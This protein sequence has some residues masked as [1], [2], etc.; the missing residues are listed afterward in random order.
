MEKP[1]Y[2]GGY[3][4]AGL[5][6]NP[7]ILNQVGAINLNVQQNTMT[8]QKYTDTI[9][10]KIQT[11]E[12]NKRRSL[13]SVFIATQNN[14]AIFLVS[15]YDNGDIEGELLT[16]SVVGNW[17][18]YRL[19]FTKTEQKN[20]K[21]AILFPL[22]NIYVIGDINKNSKN[23]LFDYFVKARI[24]FNP[25]IDDKKIKNALYTTFAPLIEN[26]EN[27]MEIPELAGWFQHKFIH[28]ANFPFAQ[29][30]G[31]PNLPVLDKKFPDLPS[32]RSFSAGYFNLIRKIN[33][34]QDRIILME[35]PLI[36]M[37]ASLLAREGLKIPFFINF[38]FCE[39]F[40][41]DILPR[42]VQIFN[43]DTVQIIRADANE[44][45]LNKELSQINDEILIFDAFKHDQGAYRGRK[46]EN[47]LRKII[48][49]IIDNT[50]AYGIPRNIH[51]MLMVISD[52]A[53]YGRKSLNIFVKK[54][55][56]H[57]TDDVEDLFRN[58]VIEEYIGRFIIYVQDHFETVVDIIKKHKK[59]ISDPRVT[60]LEI[61][62]EILQIFCSSEGYN[63][64]AEGTLP[65]KIDFL[66]FFDELLNLDDATELFIGIV[67]KQISNFLI[68]EK[69]DPREKNVYACFFNDEYLWI[70]P[71]TLDIMLQNSG[72]PLHKSA[73]LSELKIT[74]DLKADTEGLTRKLQINGKRQEFY[75][76]KREFF[77]V[78]GMADITNLGREEI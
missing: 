55:F 73:I 27:T 53:I 57:D 47:N 34:W 62:F 61:G 12:K 70:P 18:I 59:N 17:E 16:S 20:A 10:K 60:I 43:R 25:Q 7:Q 6:Q 4:Q 76:F 21:F 14:G 63:V 42:L 38:V 39:D 58:R 77:N 8:L 23:G 46:I 75:Q 51:T 40:T 3:E 56:L 29:R 49:K 64:V 66:T 41:Y 52:H 35:L 22:N 9:E 28:S 67:R 54:T 15:A 36:G 65:P 2:K 19:K 45:C 44:K 68:Y 13:D 72:S 24:V 11:L 37:L 78:I 71:I 69:N 1:I 26:C 33:R 48:N 31:V 74:G 30:N 32:D 50:S 5:Y